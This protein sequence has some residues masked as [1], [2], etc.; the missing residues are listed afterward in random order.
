MTRRRKKVKHGKIIVGRRL[1]CKCCHGKGYQKERGSRIRRMCMCCSGSG[2]QFQ[3][4][5]VE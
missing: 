3:K 1:T 5:W 2:K 4:M